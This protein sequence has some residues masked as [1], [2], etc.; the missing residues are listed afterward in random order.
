MIRTILTR[1]F[2]KKSVKDDEDEDEHIKTKEIATGTPKKHKTIKGSQKTPPKNKAGTNNVRRGS[3][4]NGTSESVVSG[5]QQIKRA[6]SGIGAERSTVPA[7]SSLARRAVSPV[8]NARQTHPRRRREVSGSDESSSSD[9]SEDSDCDVSSSEES[10]SGNSYESS[11][12]GD[13]DSSSEESEGSSSSEDRENRAISQQRAI[14]RRRRAPAVPPVRVVPPPKLILK[15]KLSPPPPPQPILKKKTRRLPSPPQPRPILKNKVKPSVPVAPPPPIPIRAFPGS[16]KKQPM[17]E[18]ATE[19]TPPLHHNND[20]SSTDES[21]DTTDSEPILQ[22]VQQKTTRTGS[23]KTPLK[24]A[25]KSNL[26]RKSLGSQ[27]A[28]KTVEEPPRRKSLNFTSFQ[29]RTLV[30]ERR[31][32]TPEKTHR[33]Y[34]EREVESE[35]AARRR[36]MLAS[37][38]DLQSGYEHTPRISKTA[39]DSLL[40]VTS[41]RDRIDM[42]RLRALPTPMPPKTCTGFDAFGLSSNDAKLE[43]QSQMSQQSR[44]EAAAAKRSFLE[45]IPSL[46]PVSGLHSYSNEVGNI[47]TDSVSSARE[48]AKEKVSQSDPLSEEYGGEQHISMRRNGWESPESCE[49]R[50][51]KTSDV[52]PKGSPGKGTTDNGTRADEPPL[53]KIQ[54]VDEASETVSAVTDQAKKNVAASKRSF[55]ESIPSIIPSSEPEALENSLD[56]TEDVWKDAFRLETDTG[57]AKAQESADTTESVARSFEAPGTKTA[58]ASK[59]TGAALPE[60]PDAEGEITAGADMN[61]NIP[62]KGEH[63]SPGLTSAVPDTGSFG[64]DKSFTEVFKRA[65]CNSAGDAIAAVKRRA[66]IGMNDKSVS[67][68][69]V[70]RSNRTVESAQVGADVQVDEGEVESRL[71]HALEEIHALQALIIEKQRLLS[72][73]AAEAKRLQLFKAK[74]KQQH[75]ICDDREMVRTA[76]Q[77]IATA[78]K[79]DGTKGED[80]FHSCDQSESVG[81]RSGA[82][83]IRTGIPCSFTEEQVLLDDRPST[84]KGIRGEPQGKSCWGATGE[85]SGG[86]TLGGARARDEHR[87]VDGEK[88]V[89]VELSVHNVVCPSGDLDPVLLVDGE[90]R[91]STPIDADSNEPGN[92]VDE[93]GGS[94]AHD[95]EYEGKAVTLFAATANNEP[96]QRPVIRPLLRRL[97][98]TAI[99]KG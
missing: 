78:S 8:S 27:P 93:G 48:N 26:R 62:E 65:T 30:A 41:D 21:A 17:R 95:M 18:L 4:T 12:D 83:S 77:D 61:E 29:R 31:P 36:D 23:R 94:E 49:I 74:L 50:S 96:R 90:G 56:D 40:P 64:T 13:S 57:T 44:E 39:D 73:K 25:L 88:G 43:E 92:G 71:F 97:S 1:T 52:A 7:A 86:A 5:A 15:N 75:N 69:P 72:D 32:S 79:D 54:F 59:L 76:E 55:L 70:K 35:R 37:F 33:G 84:V 66:D 28:K 82:T 2:S 11:E 91:A 60:S 58:V 67:V 16:P 85:F 98:M 3:S 6:N 42:G 47:Q 46:I 19:P 45:D 24:P 63:V 80:Q 99:V 38:A 87:D 89:G 22:P 53:G 9:S 51:G 20:E 10:S 14:R 81:K 34:V 68:L